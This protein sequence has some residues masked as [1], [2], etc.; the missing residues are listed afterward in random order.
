MIERSFAGFSPSVERALEIFRASLES[1]YGARL[2]NML[3]FG[4]RARGDARGD[5]DVDV[6][7]VLAGDLQ[8]GAKEILKVARLSYDAVVETGVQVEGWPVSERQWNDPSLHRNPSLIL[9]MKRDGIP[10]EAAVGAP[11]P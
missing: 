5:S 4:S 9:A 7:V 10:L 8:P 2:R 3:V 1:E 11:S 6:A